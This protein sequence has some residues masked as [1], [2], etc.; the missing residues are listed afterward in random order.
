MAQKVQVLITDDIDGSDG[1][2]SV[3]FGLDGVTY[4]ID[5]S[6]AN[7][8]KLRKSLATYVEHGRKVTAA[9]RTAARASGK[10]KSDGVNPQEV[11]AWA[12][13]QGIEVSDRGRVPNDLVARFQAANA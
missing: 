11:R 12:K 7:A 1:A 9:K 2:G 6:E 5:L 8:S 4:E 10:A 3:T 13:Q